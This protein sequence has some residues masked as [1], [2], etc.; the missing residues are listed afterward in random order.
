MLLRKYNSA[1]SSAQDMTASFN[2]SDTVLPFVVGYSIQA[3]ITGTPVGTLKLQA[4]NDDTAST[5]T[6]WSDVGG[7]TV[8]VNGAGSVMW[9]YNNPNYNHVRMVY[10]ATSSSGTLNARIC[11][12]NM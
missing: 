3:V 4:S 10:T 9:D 5:P 12:K 2:S 1:I 8:A 11:Y 6:N 7:S